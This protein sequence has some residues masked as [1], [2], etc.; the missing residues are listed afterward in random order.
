MK[1]IEKSVEINFSNIKKRIAPKT[2]NSEEVDKVF[3]VQ[4]SNF[5]F[6]K[7]KI[8]NSITANTQESTSVSAMNQTFQKTNLKNSIS[9]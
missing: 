7:E 1:Y 3:K 5:Q 6:S 2:R 8:T 9:I 4:K